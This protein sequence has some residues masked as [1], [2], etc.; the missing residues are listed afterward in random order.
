MTFCNTFESQGRS[1][2]NESYRISQHSQPQ[3]SL[4]NTSQP[5]GSQDHSQP[6]DDL[7]ME[8]TE[9]EVQIIGII[10]MI[11]YICILIRLMSIIYVC[12]LIMLISILL[13]ES[14]IMLM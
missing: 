7:D 5:Q 6:N 8:S 12:S 9:V 2:N 14:T 4:Q 13:K 3:A 1:H 11:I 10:Y